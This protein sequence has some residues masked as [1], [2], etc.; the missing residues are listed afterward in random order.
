MSENPKALRALADNKPRLDLIEPAFELAVAPVMAHGAAKY[1]ARN[2]LRDPL[3]KST[4]YAAMK[5]HIDAWWM[6]EEADPD[7][8]QSHLAHLG[9]N[10]MILLAVGDALIDDSAEPGASR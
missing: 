4:V 8:G 5:R 9:A 10:V 7:S 2:Y 6:G 1:G 3:R